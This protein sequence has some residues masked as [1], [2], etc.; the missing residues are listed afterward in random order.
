MNMIIICIDL[1]NTLAIFEGEE[2]AEDDED[3]GGG[4]KVT[5]ERERA[6]E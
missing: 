6:R 2:D 3:E 1:F 4:E 5:S